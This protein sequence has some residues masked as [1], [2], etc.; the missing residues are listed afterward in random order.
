VDDSGPAAERLPLFPASWYLFGAA[1][2]LRRGPCSRD[3]LGRRLVAYRTSTG[4]AVVLDGRC[5]HLGAD[6]GAGCVVGD[7][8]R[9]SFHNW[10]YEPDGRC[11][12]VPALAYPPAF[13][14]QASFPVVERHGYVF[15][16][17]G[18]EPSF[19]LPFFPGE[20][21]SQHVAARPLRFEA[22]APWYL[23]NGNSFDAQHF[24][25]SHHRQLLDEPVVDCPHPFARRI[26]MTFGVVGHSLF[27]HLLRRYVGDRVAVSITSW[28]G[29]VL[30]VTGDFRRARSQMLAFIEPLDARHSAQNVLVYARRLLPGW[31]GRLLEPL[32]LAVR[33]RF[34]HAFMHGEFEELAG[35]CYRPET[36]VPGDRV[37]IDFFRWVAGLP[38]A[39]PPADALP[40]PAAECT[41]VLAR[42]E[43][44]P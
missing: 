29:T 20:E 19:P 39:A 14:R 25:A 9:C 36:V 7:R 33:R 31:L 42:K 3:L 17:N 38:Q 5:A 4:R 16:F 34:T 41:P 30:V 32:R 18:P 1:R 13:A 8:L 12:F 24:L 15:F 11:A 10:E 6:L 37:M 21:I 23:V 43:G 2:E 40:K 22:D 27:D 35:I 28:G 26:R 44:F